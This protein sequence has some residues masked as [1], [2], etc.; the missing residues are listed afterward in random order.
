[1]YLEKVGVRSSFHYQTDWPLFRELVQAGK[2]PVFKYSWGADVPDPDSIISPLFHSGSPQ[3]I[4][5]YSSQKVDQIIMRAQNESDYQKRIALY[6]EAQDL[7]MDDAPVILM[8][9]LAYVRI[10]QPYVRN[11]EGKALG[12]QYFSLKRIWLHRH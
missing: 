7:I 3:N 4:A 8:N 6:A 11:F 9:Y 12:D 2:A 1:M 5:F 10:F